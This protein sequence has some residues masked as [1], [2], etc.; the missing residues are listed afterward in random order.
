MK[1]TRR[2]ITL[3]LAML[4]ICALA[5]TAS[6]TP[7][8]GK[9]GTI[10]VEGAVLADP[11]NYTVYTVYK[12]FDV[13]DGNSTDENKYKAT[14]E[15]V[16]F[17]KQ[18]ELEPYFVVQETNEGTYMIWRKNTAS[19]ADAAA[20]AELARDYV[21][22]K[23]LSNVGTVTV[24]GEALDVEDNGYYLLVPNNTTASGVIVVK[25]EQAKV[26]TE[27][28]VAPGMPTVEKKVYEDS[29]QAYVDGNTAD[30]GQDIT[31]KITI[32]AGQGAS[33]YVLHDSM[34]DHIAVDYTSGSITRGGNPVAEEE[35]EIV[36]ENIC[37]NCTFHVVFD[38]EWCKGL[39]DGAVIVVT[40]KGYLLYEDAEGNK[41][42]T[43]TAHE[44][45]AWLTH[46]AQNVETP[47]STVSS[48]TC[49]INVL[50]VDQDEVALA[51]A[52]FKLRDNE[53]RYYKFD[54]ATKTVSWVDEAN[55]TEVFSDAQGKLNFYGV[56]A[57]IFYL[58][59]TTV[60]GGYTGVGETQV[61]VKNGS[62]TAVNPVTVVNTLGQKLPETG[63]IGTT[64][65]YIGGAVL[66]LVALGALI[67]IK[68]KETSAQ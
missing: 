39:N 1:T 10:K 20:I 40:Y 3:A 29:L 13:D 24:N 27:K 17:V 38:E 34:D 7:A 60:P 57:E 31:Y 4:M 63:G 25:N 9:G 12:M 37:P 67:V 23:S 26:I 41:V 42:A 58:K 15:W 55:A 52:G 62:I 50:K 19:T 53:N 21:A 61:N 65:F 59:E 6:A 56:D 28:S 54:D 22:E 66:V 49:E 16:D 36:T 30:I 14:A 68:R 46:T 33:N 2:L 64:V 43:D 48:K 44:N 47:K 32:T 5:I 51:G 45:T 8:D 11:A 35:Y 18:A